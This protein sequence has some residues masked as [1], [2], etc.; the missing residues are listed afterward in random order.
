MG[1]R[2][3]TRVVSVFL[4]LA[5]LV[6]APAAVSTDSIPAAGGNIA[7]TP[8]MHASVQVEHAGKVIHVDPWS[9]GD[10]SNAKP[11][12]LILITDIHEDHLDLP[13]V[14]KIRKP[15][16]PV[17]IP[18]ASREKVPD[19]SVLANGETK[20]GCGCQR[21]SGRAVRPEVQGLPLAKPRI[22]R[23]RQSIST[24]AKSSGRFRTATRQITFAITP[25][26][27]A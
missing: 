19:G 27:R 3:V 18:A 24:R 20:N 21:R 22:A 14:Q 26:S 11:A 15:S 5:Y 4:V 13:A 2:G 12:E 7:I 16:A 8:I 6:A 17:V 10:Y 9:Q 23:S 25:R 1:Q